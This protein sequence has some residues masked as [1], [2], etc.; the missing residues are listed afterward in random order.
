MASRM[1]VD[2]ADGVVEG[3]VDGVAEAC[4]EGVR[5]SADFNNGVDF[6]YG[7]AEPFAEGV[8]A[9]LLEGVPADFTDFAG[10]SSALFALLSGEGDGSY[11]GIWTSNFLFFF[12]GG[13]SVKSIDILLF[14]NGFAAAF[15]CAAGAVS[16]VNGLSDTVTVILNRSSDPGV[17]KEVVCGRRMPGW[18]TSGFIGINVFVFPT[19]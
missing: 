5:L 9:V 10:D 4:A 15:L 16:L 17:T 11:C 12:C 6:A 13:E 14:G 8:E 7:V 2:F 1:G 19:S 18:I 3:F